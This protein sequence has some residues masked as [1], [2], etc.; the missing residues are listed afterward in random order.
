MVFARPGG[1][2][3]VEIIRNMASPRSGS[4][5]MLL[6]STAADSGPGFMIAFVVC[7]P[8]EPRYEDDRQFANDLMRQARSMRSD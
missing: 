2:A 1:R 5:D 8:C 7:K 6:D 4:P 3:M